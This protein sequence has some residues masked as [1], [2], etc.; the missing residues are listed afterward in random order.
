MVGVK[1]RRFLLVG[2]VWKSRGVT[3]RQGT[4]LGHTGH[5]GAP[6]RLVNGQRK[7]EQLKEWDNTVI[8]IS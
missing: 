8:Q 4:M 7:N 3:R 6:S 2:D 1:P 5:G